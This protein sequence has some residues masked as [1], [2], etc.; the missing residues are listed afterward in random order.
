M[1]KHRKSVGLKAKRSGD[2]F[3]REIMMRCGLERVG[4]IRI[5]NGCKWISGTKVVPVKSP[6]DFIMV[7]EGKIAFIDTKV[8]GAD[9]LSFSDLEP[10][11]LRALRLATDTT[12]AIGGY[13]CKLSG[14]MCFF[15]IEQLCNLERHESLRIEDGLAISNMRDFL[16]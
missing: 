8:R 11:Q 2:A 15:S 10:H 4:C 9:R 3:E 12:E 13:L 6:F 7:Y 1:V 14:V 16:S 5:P